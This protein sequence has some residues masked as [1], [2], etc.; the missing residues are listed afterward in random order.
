MGV[1]SIKQRDDIAGIISVADKIDFKPLLYVIAA[2][3][4]SK[5]LIEPSPSEKAYPFSKEY[6]ILD[7]PRKFFDIIEIKL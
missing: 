1:I 3:K 5:L 6:K 4:V 2:N 7:L